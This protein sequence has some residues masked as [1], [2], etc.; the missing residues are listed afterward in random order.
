M[1]CP[2]CNNVF[3]SKTNLNT[4]QKTAK[5]CLKLQ[6]I[7]I[8][9]HFICKKCDKTFIH[10]HIYQKH[11]STC[12]NTDTL[13]ENKLLKQENK[14]LKET[15]DKLEQTIKELQDDLKDVAVSAVSRP[16]SITN[17]TNNNTSNTQNILMNLTPFE[18]NKENFTEKIQ[19]HFDKNYLVNGQKGVVQF[20]VEK[21]LKDKDG[22][23]MYICTDPSRQIYRFKSNDGIIE[24]DVKAKKLTSVF[25]EEIKGKSYTITNNEIQNGNSDMFLEY[26]GYFQ[27]IKELED[28]NAEF[29]IELASLTSM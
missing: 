21:I 16:T 28:D 24:R 26:S 15:I 4:H 29:R 20:V 8:P 10:K 25:Y 12:I 2:Y 18:M 19:D 7:N 13:E 17:N 9:V 11:I 22:K 14:Y 1:E 5:Y 27:D 23:L 3:S 6:E